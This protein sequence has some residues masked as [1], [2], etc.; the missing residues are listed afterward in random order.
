MNRAVEAEARLEGL[1]QARLA[2]SRH[3]RATMLRKAESALD[4]R[5]DEDDSNSRGDLSIM[6]QEADAEAA[7][8]ER[9][10]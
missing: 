8:N 6:E 10:L 3:E 1:A 5:H 7:T 4:S 2:E 9:K